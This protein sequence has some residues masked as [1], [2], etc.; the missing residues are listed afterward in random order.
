MCWRD[1]A[2]DASPEISTKMLE[3]S[4]LGT[5]PLL[6]RTTMHEQLLGADYPLFIDEGD[7]LATLRP[8]P[9]IP[10][11]SRMPATVPKLPC[12]RIR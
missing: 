3:C 12:G 11:S 1:A 5:P 2:L 9:A 8:S 7:V 10:S 4:A 6:N